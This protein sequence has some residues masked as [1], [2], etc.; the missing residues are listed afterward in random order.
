MKLF[1]LTANQQPV[2]EKCRLL[3]FCLKNEIKFLSKTDLNDDIRNSAEGK[4]QFDM[5]KSIAKVCFNCLKSFESH[6]KAIVYLRKHLGK[7]KIS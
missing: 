1:S 6:S 2:E 4:I 5:I 7:H 3:L